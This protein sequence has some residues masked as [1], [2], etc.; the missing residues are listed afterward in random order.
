M[1]YNASMRLAV[2]VTLGLLLAAGACGENAASRHAAAQR[3]REAALARDPEFG[4]ALGSALLEQVAQHAP[5]WV[6]RESLRRGTLA[7]RAR[8]AFL[9]VLPYGHCYRFVASGGA[10]V[11]DLD[12]ALFDSNNVE[13]ARDTSEDPAPVLGEAASICPS[14]ASAVRVEARMRRGSG[15]FALGVFQSP[16]Q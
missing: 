5:G 15:E 12:L 10:G 14:D 3:E 11:I 13:I 6:K 4:D 7:E 16:D 8:Q 9:V 2:R 1:V